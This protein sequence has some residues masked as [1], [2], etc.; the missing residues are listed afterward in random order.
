MTYGVGASDAKAPTYDQLIAGKDGSDAD[1]ITKGTI[2][3]ASKSFKSKIASAS[4]KDN[5][6]YKVYY[7]LNTA[8]KKQ[9]DV[10]SYDVKKASLLSMIGAFA[11]LMISVLAF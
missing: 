8:D 5:T 9:Q 3:A 11:V 7:A 10:K 1:F 2:K 6:S 4:L